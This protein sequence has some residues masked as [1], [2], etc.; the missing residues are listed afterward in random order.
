[1]FS[2]KSLR[3]AIA[4][5][6][7]ALALS[8]AGG[9]QAGVVVKSSG[10]SASKY[11]VGKKLDDAGTVTLEE[12]DTLTILADGG[13]RVIRGPGTHRVAARGTSRRSTFARLT[14]QR[15]RSRVRTGATRAPTGTASPTSSNLWYVDVSKSGT[16]C[17]PSLSDVQLFRPGGDQASTYMISSTTTPEH[18]HVTF[19]K[20]QSLAGWDAERMPFSEDAEYVITGPTG[21]AQ[22]ITFRTLAEPADTPEGLAEQLIEKGCM[23]Q[24]DLLAEKMI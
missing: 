7:G 6:G 2:A 12:G 3:K 16:M 5:A 23:A 8:L 19:A 11:P 15:S 4:L 14:S 18:L 9:A 24:L 21:E 22:T 13:T 1:M 10:P 20:D 17:V